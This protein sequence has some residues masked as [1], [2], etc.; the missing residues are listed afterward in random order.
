MDGWKPETFLLA[1][2]SSFACLL[3]LLLL[4]AALAT[5]PPP[6]A[7]LLQL[8]QPSEGRW[9]PGQAGGC[10]RASSICLPGDAT[11]PAMT[12]DGGAPAEGPTAGR[13]WRRPPLHCA[14]SFIM[15]MGRCRVRQVLPIIFQRCSWNWNVLA[16][17]I[18]ATMAQH[19]RA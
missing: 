5:T 3:L 6:M 16:A 4:V 2:S 18:C 1:R 9:L 7:A 17:T 13:L 15:F 10:R 12:T 14:A 8:G 19:N 11:A